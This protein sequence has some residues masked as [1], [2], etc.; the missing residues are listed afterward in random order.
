MFEQIWNSI[1]DFILN[2]EMYVDIVRIIADI[3]ILTFVIYKV[4]VF[5]VRSRAGKIIKGLILL[6]IFTGIINMFGLPTLKWI[7]GN[8]FSVGII[9]L[10]IIFQPE[11]RRMLENVGNSSSNNFKS[12]SDDEAYISNVVNGI[13]EVAEDMSEKRWGLLIVIERKNTLD[14]YIKSG[15]LIGAQLT[16]ELLG[17]IFTH[18]A[19]LHD[20][21][22][23]VRGDRIVAASCMLPLTQNQ[24]LSSQLGMRHRAAIGITEHTDA[25]SIVV[26]EETGYISIAENSVLNRN[27]TVQRLREV[28]LDVFTSNAS[29]KKNSKS[30]LKGKKTN[31]KNSK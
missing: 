3:F 23:I 7:V 25:I 18:N 15:I 9:A 22:V 5:I 19:P 8:V 13:V 17:N 6:L 12:V 1:N 11:L 30:V 26:S 14:D 21:A 27:V 10:M 29:A 4:L 24:F 31:A 20:G 28:L 2:N 16:E